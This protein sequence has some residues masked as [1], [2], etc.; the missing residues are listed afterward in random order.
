MPN[1][2][3]LH[4]DLRAKIDVVLAA[5][6]VLGFP[7]KIIQ[8]VRTVQEQQKLYAQGRTAPGNIVTNC[9]GVIKTSNHQ[10]KA[11]GFGHAAD[12]AFQGAEPFGEKHPWKCYGE[13]AKALGLKWGGDWKTPDRPHVELI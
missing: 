3:K 11:D 2:D 8:G 12:L 10:I 1:L 9:D 5:M 13:C 7:M 6:A 4:P